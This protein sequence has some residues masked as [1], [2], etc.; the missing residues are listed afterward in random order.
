MIFLQTP[1]TLGEDLVQEK[2]LSVLELIVNGG[3]SSLIIIGILFV[4]LAVALYI[5]FE[6]SFAIRAASKMDAN[7]MNMIRENISSGRL[8]AAKMLCNQ[9]KSPVYR[10]VGKGI[11]HIGKPLEDINKAIENAAALEVYKLEKN[12]SILATIAGAGP[13]IGFLGTVV[14]MIMAF[15]QMASS[16]GQAEMGVLA[17]GIYT[18]MTTTVAGLIVGIIAYVGYN[19]LVVK[20]NKVV[21]KMEAAAVD[22][23]DLLNEPI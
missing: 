13:M 2:T 15:H 21:H 22:F 3:T 9:S 4:M 20:T 6:R 5:Y 7:F 10:L 19:H 16:G 11:S 18:A 1:A 8:E 14:G 17:Q 12:T 23:L